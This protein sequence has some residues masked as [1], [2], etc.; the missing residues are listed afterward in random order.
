MTETRN[1]CKELNDS[2]N[3]R[4]DTPAKR[5][6]VDISEGTIYRTMTT[7]G[8]DFSPSMKDDIIAVLDRLDELDARPREIICTKCGIRE[9]KGEQ[10]EADF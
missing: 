4:Y 7:Q 6:R 9:Q 10:P 8:A 1:E 2:N 5:L 3:S